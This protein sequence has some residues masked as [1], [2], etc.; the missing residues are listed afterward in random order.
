MSPFKGEMTDYI[1]KVDNLVKKC[2]GLVAVDDIRFSVAGGE[3]FV[4]K[5]PIKT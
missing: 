4:P 1:I 3:I 2:G 5:I